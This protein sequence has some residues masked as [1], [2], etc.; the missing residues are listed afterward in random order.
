MEINNISMRK[1]KLRQFLELEPSLGIFIFYK[2]RMK[3]K[4]KSNVPC[5]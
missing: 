2:R 5:R 1:L 3:Q 4:Q